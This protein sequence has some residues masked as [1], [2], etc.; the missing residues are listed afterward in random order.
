MPGPGPW[1][2]W[3]VVKNQ[4]AAEL[5][6]P[7]ADLAPE[8]D[9]IISRATRTA[10]ER[11]YTI[12]AHKGYAAD[13]IAAA[14]QAPVWHEDLA[15]FFS[16]V[17]G[18]SLASYPLDSRQGVRLPQG[19]PGGGRHPD[20][21]QTR[22]AGRRPTPSAFDPARAVQRPEGDR[23]ATPEARPL[24]LGGGRCGY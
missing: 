8:W 20:R 16:M 22:R 2:D 9:T 13:Q 7:V 4:V 12:L 6:V 14:D 19:A 11:I 17:K 15:V 24:R 18:T 5:H 23:G 1:V 21:R 3:L 10:Q